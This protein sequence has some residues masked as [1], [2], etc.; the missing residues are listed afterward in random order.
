MAQCKVLE[1]VF[2]DFAI[3]HTGDTICSVTNLEKSC[4]IPAIANW[5]RVANGVGF[6]TFM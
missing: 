5:G 3:D 4:W 2:R 6:L 1:F